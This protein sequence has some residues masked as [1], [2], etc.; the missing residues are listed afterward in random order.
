MSCTAK[1][2]PLKGLFRA[3][4]G[5]WLGERG[6]GTQW[7]PSLDT[8]KME[9]SYWGA[10]LVLLIAMSRRGD[11]RREAG[12]SPLFLSFWR[13]GSF[14]AALP[15]PCRDALPS[16]VSYVIAVLLKFDETECFF[17]VLG[18]W[19]WHSYAHLP[20]LNPLPPLQSCPRALWTPFC[21][22]QSR[23]ERM[24]LPPLT[25]TSCT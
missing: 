5:N 9:M 24:C 7:P 17:H 23:Q 13:R 3:S 18:W 10:A 2:G 4:I 16:R 14:P 19:R 8:E 6:T 20:S 12:M 15:P 1:T 21:Q 22:G 11:E 25:C